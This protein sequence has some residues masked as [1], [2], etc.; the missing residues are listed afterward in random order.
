[1]IS[2]EGEGKGKIRTSSKDQHVDTV[3]A[4]PLLNSGVGADRSFDYG[5][6]VHNVLEDFGKVEA[7]VAVEDRGNTDM[8][9]GVA[10]GADDLW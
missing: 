8:C 10:D 1:V 2:A 6:G 4:Q 9:E 3:L 7:E 5:V